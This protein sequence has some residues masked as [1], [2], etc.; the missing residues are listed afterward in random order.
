[1]GQDDLRVG[2]LSLV[3]DDRDVAGV[4]VEFRYRLSHHERGR[5]PAP[6]R[7]EHVDRVTV[8]ADDPE[9]LELDVHGRLGDCTVTGRQQFGD[10]AP[11]T[12]VQVDG[13]LELRSADQFH[14]GHRP[15]EQAGRLAPVDAVGSV[16]PDRLVVPDAVLPAQPVLLRVRR[17]VG[18]AGGPVSAGLVRGGAVVGRDS[19]S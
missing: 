19:L 1:V 5:T 12:E 11:G 8:L 13:F 4:E 2:R 7:P 18:V 9:G 6:C 14:A 15:V 16:D 17:R 3:D 10:L